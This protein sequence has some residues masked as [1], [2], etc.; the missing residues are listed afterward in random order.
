MNT[1][2]ST[3]NSPSRLLIVDDEEDIRQP[4]CQHLQNS[5]FETFAAANADQAYAQLEK[6]PIDLVVLD[7]MMPGTSGLEVCRKLSENNGP[8]VILLTALT[9][10]IE[11]IIGLEIGADDYVSKP[12]NPR[13]LVARIRSVLRRTNRS[14][15]ATSSKIHSFGDW[16][17]H[18]EQGELHHRDETVVML[19]T[20]ESRLLKVFVDNQNKILSRD[21][22]INLTQGR[23]SFPYERSIDN[24]VSRLRRKIEADLSKPKH[25]VTVWGGGYKFSSD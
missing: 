16:Q 10:D 19:S 2:G 24:M 13:E 1:P 12:F 23:D 21:E 8:P 20:G 7:V 15:S 4:L 5:G 3:T 18:S 14:S 22:L 25:I 9:E 11:R 17:W 6:H